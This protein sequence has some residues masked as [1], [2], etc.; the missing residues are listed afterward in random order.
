MMSFAAIRAY[1]VGDINGRRNFLTK[2]IAAHEHPQ[3]ELLSD[4]TFSQLF[5]LIDRSY[6]ASF[7]PCSD[8][9]R[10]GLVQH[11]RVGMRGF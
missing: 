5:E 2:T 9:R 10:L 4:R 1:K 11:H 8:Q 3:S 7:I 6:G